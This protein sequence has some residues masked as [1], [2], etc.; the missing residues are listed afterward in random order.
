MMLKGGRHFMQISCFSSRECMTSTDLELSPPN[1]LQMR[2]I[3]PCFCELPGTPSSQS[4]LEFF[5]DLAVFVQNQD[6]SCN[7]QLV[8]SL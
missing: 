7:C 4:W 5:C 8:K 3:C 6:V 2:D 1:I